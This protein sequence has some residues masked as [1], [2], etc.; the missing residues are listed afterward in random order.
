MW[1]LAFLNKSST[2]RP[3]AALALRDEVE[4]LKNDLKS[5]TIQV[6]SATVSLFRS[7][8]LLQAAVIFREAWRMTD[9]PTMRGA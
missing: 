8:T 2:L 9:W 5:G 3:L 1:R 7:N 4:E 6:T